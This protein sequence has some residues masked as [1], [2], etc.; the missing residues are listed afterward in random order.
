MFAYVEI[1]PQ[2][3]H[4]LVFSIF[5]IKNVWVRLGDWHV[6]GSKKEYSENKKTVLQTPTSGYQESSAQLKIILFSIILK[7][8]KTSSMSTIKFDH[9]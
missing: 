8:Y 4:I 5:S 9:E 2:K 7:S 1:I 3:C 6:K